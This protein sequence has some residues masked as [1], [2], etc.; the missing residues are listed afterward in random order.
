VVPF[1]V[2][3]VVQEF[4]SAPR[5]S[6]MVANRTYLEAADHAGGPNVVFARADD[7]TG[8]AHRIAAATASDGTI[9]KDINEQ[10]KQTA[11]SITTVDLRGV[12]RILEAF[13][14]ILAAAAMGLFVALGLVERRQEF[15]TMAAL[16]ARLRDI[17]AFVWSEAGLVLVAAMV[18]AGGLGWLLSEMLVAMLQHVF[19]PPPDALAVPWRY[20][21]ELCG[22][23]VVGAGVATGVASRGL[24]RMQVGAIL[25]EE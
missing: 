25:R 22:A 19:D 23:A 16:G 12:S 13:T 9:V 11:S 8:T 14:V 4:P 7:P 24:A 2:V 6:F 18:L 5:D 20:L 21:L 10:S 17:S 3:G 15:A 1:H